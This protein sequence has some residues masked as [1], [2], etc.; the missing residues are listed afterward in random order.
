MKLSCCPIFWPTADVERK[1]QKNNGN[2]R[3]AEEKHKSIKQIKE[4][5]RQIIG[6]NH[7]HK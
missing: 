1:C 3:K 2:E 4:S 7:D 6:N 5:A